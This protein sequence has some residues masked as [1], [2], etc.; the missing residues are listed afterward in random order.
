MKHIIWDWNGTLLHDLPVIID[1]V[2]AAA[3]QVGLPKIE[4]DDYR[5][6]YTRP[7]KVFY[8]RIA[9]RSI[10]DEEWMLIDRLFHEE[11]HATVVNA[12]L[13]VG[14]HD[15]LATID[16]G[17]HSQS[18]LSMAPHDELQKAIALF[19]VDRYFSIAQGNT[20]RPGD[21]KSQHLGMH[22]S[23]LGVA[24]DTIVMIGDTVDD[25]ESARE[26]DVAC[27]LYDDGSHH[28]PDL[29]AVGVPITDSLNEAVAWAVST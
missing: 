28:R 13:A 27:V 18:L 14:A 17:P 12:E 22:L 25:A 9:G 29:E 4:L 8:E 26:H 5:T 7:V 15:A 1:A 16:G 3:A 24:R 23:D 6:H 20:G 11:Y 19:G 21:P 2:N 10:D